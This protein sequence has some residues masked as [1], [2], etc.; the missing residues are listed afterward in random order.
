M[1]EQL[2]EIEL[3]PQVPMPFVQ[4]AAPL[5]A[6]AICEQLGSDAQVLWPQTV[7]LD[8]DEA[9]WVSAKAGYD[10]GIF[11]QLRI[12]F[13]EPRDDL[14]QI[15]A[16][17]LARA[18][19]WEQAI[20][21]GRSAAGPLA[22]FASDYF[23]RMA[24]LGGTV[25]LLFPNGNLYCRALLEGIDVWGRICVETDDGRDVEYSPAQVSMRLI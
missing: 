7:L 13:D 22:Q 17:I 5:A 10:E 12:A 20:G 11:V 4:A 25:E 1:G 23:D 18:A 15:E 16:A 24:G 14:G 2:L 21:A 9:A 19:A 6:L 3:R 8:G